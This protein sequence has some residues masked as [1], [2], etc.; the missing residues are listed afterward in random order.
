M[1]VFEGLSQHL[2]HRA[3]KLGKFIE[4]EY[5]VM[6]QRNLAR[7]GVRTAADHGDG[8]YGV[9]RGAERA[10]SHQPRPTAQL[11]GNRVNLCSLEGLAKCERRHNRRQSLCHHRLTRA[12]RTDKQYVV[13][14]GA[15]DFEGTFHIFLAFYIAEIKVEVPGLARKLGA[16][17]DYGRLESGVATQKICYLAQV[18]DSVDLEIIY[19]CRLGSI[20]RRQYHALEAPRTGLD[21]HRQGT[22]DGLHAAVERQFAHNHITVKDFRLDNL[23]ADKQRHGNRQVVGRALLAYISRRHVDDCGRARHGITRMCQ[24]GPHAL[25]ALLYRRVGQADDTILHTTGDGSLDGYNPC[26]NT[27]HGSGVSLDK[28]Q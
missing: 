28:H 20:G 2:E 13:P 19:H 12:G 5:A 21:S 23:R 24:C 15:G 8:R 14:T 17:I 7:H 26:I 4:E 10:H 22:T 3:R 27:L 11:T 1:A 9:V 25:V 6:C 16:S 18:L